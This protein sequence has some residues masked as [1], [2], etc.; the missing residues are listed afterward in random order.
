VG[1]FCQQPRHLFGQFDRSFN[2]SYVKCFHISV[3][4]P[5]VRFPYKRAQFMTHQEHQ[6]MVSILAQNLQALDAITNLL[7]KRGILTKDELTALLA[8]TR[9][10]TTDVLIDRAE[11]LYRDRAIALGVPVPP[12]IF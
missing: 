2:P 4:F 7:E 5:F 10:P 3:L 9:G 12:K 11:S 8:K 6:L 1:R